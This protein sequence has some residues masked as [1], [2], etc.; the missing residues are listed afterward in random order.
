MLITREAWTG[1]IVGSSSD[2]KDA[3]SPLPEQRAEATRTGIQRLLLVE[4]EVIVRLDIERQLQDAGYDVVAVA[5]TA[6]I[7]VRRA[8]EERPD[9]VLM[10]IRLLGARDGIDAAL[11]IWQRFGI[12]SLFLSAN[13]DARNRQRAAAADPWG[14]V[15]KPFTPHELL[16]AIKRSQ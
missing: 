5:D 9:L 10:D 16:V 8:D 7:A 12:R 2:D 4:D 15:D 6:D 13:L 3:L 11:E 1:Y 14:F